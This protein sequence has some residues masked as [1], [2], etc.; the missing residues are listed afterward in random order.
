MAETP[1]PDVPPLLA[2]GAEHLS[3]VNVETYNA[4]LRTADGF[5]GDRASKRAFQAILDDW[6]ERLRKVGEDPL[7]DSP[8]EQISKKKLDKLLTEGDAEAA[9]VIQGAIEEFS[10]EFAAVI[11]RFRRLKCWKDAE[12]IVVGGG[13]RQSR[14]G[15]L[16]I[17]RTAVLLK[18]DGHEIE[19]KPIRCEPDHAGLVGCIHLVPAWILA[20]H[21]SILAVDI[22][23]SNIR[24]G[25]VELRTKKKPDFSD[26]AVGRFEL[27]RHTDDEPKRE[28][29][30]E[31]LVDMLKGLIKGAAKDGLQLAPF[32]GI[33]CPGVIEPDGSID[34]GGQNLP[35]NWEHKSF[36]LPRLLHE[37][38]PR[39]GDH[40]TV[41]VM[42]NDAVVQGLS[43]LPFMQ[44]VEHWG[45]LT[46]GT[47][48]GNAC[49]T[50]RKGD[51]ARK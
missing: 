7:G 49:F 43:E 16:A 5:I 4:E 3:L 42:H 32:I 15:E 2:H 25:I 46:I 21:D 17:G 36:N 45:V 22:G 41:I 1:Q 40:D 10:Q 50:N 23:G 28:D 30:V 6:R 31:R 29:A 27:W 35:G 24:A 48:L 11:R 18:G 20:G 12:R 38:I 47:G 13:L 51:T 33:G 9:G 8:S 44:D 26:A 19:L 37:A 39:I 14:I 34:R